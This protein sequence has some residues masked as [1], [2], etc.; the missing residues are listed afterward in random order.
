VTLL[1]QQLTFAQLLTKWAS[2]INPVINSP[3]NNASVL[4]S[5]MLTTGHN[6]VNHLLGRN[7]QGWYPSRIRNVSATI[8]DTQDANQTPQLTLDLVASTT[9]TVDLV[10]F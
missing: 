5:V 4:K 1:P 6:S 2:I 3:T 8:Y 7:L 9:V 10:V